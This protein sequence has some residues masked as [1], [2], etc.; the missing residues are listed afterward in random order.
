MPVKSVSVTSQ[1]YQFLFIKFVFTPFRS[2][3]SNSGLILPYALEYSPPSLTKGLPWG[4]GGG[5]VGAF[6]ARKVTFVPKGP[7]AEGAE[8]C[9]VRARVG[10]G[11]LAHDNAAVSPWPP[12]LLHTKS[13]QAG[14]RA[15]ARLE[16]AHTHSARYR[17]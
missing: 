16:P 5:P 9:L 14:R 4:G 2:G 13:T 11:D 12:P 17:Q 7:F 6:C 8:F 3:M 1:I 10:S 15:G